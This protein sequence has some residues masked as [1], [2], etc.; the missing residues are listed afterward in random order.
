MAIIPRNGDCTEAKAA[1]ALFHPKHHSMRILVAAALLLCTS[2]ASKAQLWHRLT[3]GTTA[4]LRD[5]CFVDELRGWAVG[6]QST[7]V[8]TTNGGATWSPQVPPIANISFRSVFFTSANEGWASGSGG[9]LLRTVNGGTTWTPVSTGVA[10]SVTLED[11]WFT[12]AGTGY[13]VGGQGLTGTILRTTNGGTSWTTTTVQGVMNAVQ[14]VSPTKGWVC[15]N[16]GAVYH[17]SNGTTWVEQLP[18]GTDFTYV[19][20]GISM[21]N[22]N[23]GWIAGARAG[24]D[25]PPYP[26][27]IHTVD[28]GLNWTPVVTGTIAGKTDVHFFNGQEGWLSTTSPL[29]EGYPLRSTSAGGG[30]GNWVVNT[31]SLP[32]IHA[33]HFHSPTLAWGAGEYGVIVRM[34]D[35]G[36][37]IDPVALPPV[38]QL[39]PN[40]THDLLHIRT[41]AIIMSVE[42]I[43]MDGRS[44]G[45]LSRTINTVDVGSLAPGI[46]LLRVFM[47]GHAGP[48]M[49]RF[50]KE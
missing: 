17:T 37:G 11:I 8:A 40:P 42:A 50:V 32:T 45:A 46:Y 48:S 16:R 24:Y 4:H 7:I 20:Q 47:H 30:S 39:A 26:G 12:S 41:D 27:L 36:V 44:T 2:L 13:V 15:G 9:N 31:D 33:L 3:S 38:V 14:F 22:E 34:G 6:D 1:R 18:F 19:L 43:T 25:G 29:G 23:E 35:G 49:L 10:S 5:V 28:G 21:L